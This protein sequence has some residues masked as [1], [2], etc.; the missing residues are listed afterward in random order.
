MSAAGGPTGNPPARWLLY[1]AYGYTG[2]L[3]VERAMEVGLRPVVAGRDGARIRALAEEHGLEWA[4]FGLHQPGALP[5]ALR[6]VGL[7]LNAAGPFSA[8]WRP[9]L[10]ACLGAPCH[11]L[12]ITGEID[13]LEAMQDRTDEARRSGI[14]VVPAVGFD[15]VSTDCA[16]ALAAGMVDDATELVLALSVSGRASRGTTRTTLERLGQGGAVRRN[17]LI[18]PVAIGSERRTIAFTDRPRRGSAIPWGDVS[19]AYRSTGIPNITVYATLPPGLALLGRG[20]GVLLRAGPVRRAL[21][22]VVDRLVTGP[23]SEELA[24]GHARVRAEVRNDR[25]DSAAVELLT[26]NAYALTATAAVA[27]VQRVL[28]GGVRTAPGVHT[29]SVAFGADFVLELPGVERV[30]TDGAPDD[31]SGT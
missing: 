26:P 24:S 10:E 31:R 22:H 19:T 5:A 21:E 20:L 12:D 30:A 25:G 15:V 11:Y 2:R 9:V 17:G 27:A 14:H 7:V 16:A 28:G 4:A 18:V 29:P 8:T 6:D 23:G 1:G 13:V 3:I